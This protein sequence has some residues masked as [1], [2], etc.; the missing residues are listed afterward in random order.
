VGA[1]EVLRASVAGMPIPPLPPPSFTSPPPLDGARVAIVTTAGVMRLGEKA[2]THD[3]TSFR[4]FRRDEADLLIGH[5]SIS[6]DRAGVSADRNVVLP[7]D[8]LAELAA[9]GV[10]GSVADRHIS[11]MGA[12]RAAELLSTVI[13]DSGPAAAKTLRADGVDIVVLTPVCPACSR[14]VTI[15]GHVLEAEG[16][17]TVVLASNLAI[18]E[19]ARPPR[20]LFCDFPLGRPLGRPLDASFQ[21]RVLEAAL[22]L[23]ERPRGPILE[24]FPEKIVDEVDTAVACVL[25]PRYDAD[26]PPAVDEARGLRPAWDRT[27]TEFGSSQLGRR[28]DADAVPGAI[29]RLLA[30][31]DG[32]RWTEQFDD[33]DEVLQTVADVRVYY[34]EAAL[35]LADHVPAA[36]SAETWFYQ[37]T[38]A[39]RVLKRMTDV[40]LDTGQMDELGML[41]Q[42]YIVPLSQ[43]D[44]DRLRAPWQDSSGPS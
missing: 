22:S 34:E 6:F 33:P 42:F 17:A 41:A 8:R 19:R 30:V 43:V 4:V 29:A 23:L 12:L 31:A 26:L 18:T 27:R 1:D 15:L 28:F 16:L 14:T 9:D 40:L 20:A 21:R 39:G 2:W 13:L 32:A 3:D 24:T 10:I 7:I 5:V 44:G 11:F 25:P 37:H 38:E 36:R 35:G